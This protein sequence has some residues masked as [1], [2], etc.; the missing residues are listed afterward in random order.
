MRRIRTV[1]AALAATS[2]AGCMTQESAERAVAAFGGGDRPDSLPTMLNE[3]PPFL[4]PADL[5][6]LKVQGNV[7]LRL[8]VDTAGAIVP[9]STSVATS[10]GYPGLDSAAVKGSERLQ[11][12]PAKKG[13]RAVSTP[14]LLPVFFRHP[15]A[16][17]LP[18]D[19]V[20]RPRPTLP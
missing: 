5:Y 14:V 15:G 6:A 12:A 2:L 8:F 3:S 19:T 18:G 9:E 16:P 4:Y 13:P 17:P 11:F 10:S 1:L 7:T 20:L